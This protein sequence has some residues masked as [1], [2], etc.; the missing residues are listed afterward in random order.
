MA[1][2]TTLEAIF[3]GKAATKVLLFI[4]NYGEGY[5]SQI[6]KTFAMPVSEVRKQ[7]N[8]FEN[9]GIL[10]SRPVGTSRIYTW[11][12]RDPGLEGLRRLLRDTLDKGI[13][14]ETLEQ[15]YRQRQRP[16]RKGKSL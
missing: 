16:R 15:F 6:A 3:A 11:N 7:L 12:P 2:Q 10:V 14:E 13:P 9:A 5:A 4:E 8:K 1:T